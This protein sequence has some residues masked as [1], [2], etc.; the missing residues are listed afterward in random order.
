MQFLDTLTNLAE[1]AAGS[2]GEAFGINI[3]DGVWGGWG[4]VGQIGTYYW[5]QNF[6][7]YLNS[8]S[9]IMGSKGNW[10]LNPGYS[11]KVVS[12]D[13]TTLFAPF[14]EFRLPINPAAIQQNE[15]FAI[16]FKPTQNGMVI[17]HSGAIFKEIVISGTCGQAPSGGM[18]KADEF[19]AGG[20]LSSTVNSLPAIANAGNSF[21]NLDNPAAGLMNSLA[22]NISGFNTSNTGYTWTHLL[23]NYIRSYAQVKT[24]PQG[25]GLSLVF[26]N[27][28]DNEEWMC[29]PTGFDISR[30]AG[31]AFLYDYRITLRAYKKNVPSDKEGLF[32][33]IINGIENVEN[34]LNNATAIIGGGYN[35]LTSTLS[36]V[37]QIESSFIT[38][39]MSPVN[40]LLTTLNGVK[41]TAA[42]FP[43]TQRK[44]WAG[45][46]EDVKQVKRNWED[47]TGQGSPEYNSIYTR[48]PGA[49][50]SA[51]RT[52][53]VGEV[54]ITKALD[55]IIRGTNYVLATNALFA[56]DSVD[57]A[58]TSVAMSR[59]T[60]NTKL[61]ASSNL[62]KRVSSKAQIERAFNNTVR[63]NSP[64]STKQ[65]II[66]RGDS[67][68][69]IALRTTGNVADWV[70]IAMINDLVYPYIDDIISLT[71]NRVKKF[72]DQILI[73]SSS[74]TI[75]NSLPTRETFMTSALTPQEKFLG[76]DLRVNQDFDLILSNS[77]D[78]QLSFGT[79]NALQAINIK[80][81]LEKGSLRYHPGLGVSL[82]VG[83]KTPMVAQN[84]AISIKDTL[85]SDDRFEDVSNINVSRFNSTYAIEL[86]V[87]VANYNSPVPLT[88]KL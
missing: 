16:S 27:R 53:S 31:K 67:L 82:D 76:I 39:I 51:Q 38:T 61:N 49:T 62:S 30:A 6:K 80:L 19:I 74:P 23:R 36:T 65:I 40:N 12:S 69:S 25:L 44:I 45:F 9:D 5:T 54:N 4:N 28:K 63:L 10:C 34:I 35:F 42:Q 88:I 79:Y 3:L 22:S 48:V 66:N 56:T 50:P 14:G 87:K 1:D 73:P 84:L 32:G 58:I 21:S 55:D 57:P 46:Q 37:N 77:Q 52:P 15:E 81:G 8:Y 24:I 11:F 71:N 75:S 83:G 86:N 43:A 72:G 64:Q 20:S 29:E 78:L 26:V 59:E 17:E 47:L 33:Q 70:E 41:N 60:S 85:L 7:Q 2:F 13:S 68:E 18:A